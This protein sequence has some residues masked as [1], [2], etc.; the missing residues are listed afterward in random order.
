MKRT[1]V[2]LFLAYMV[3]ALPGFAQ[4]GHGSLYSYF[5]AGT[6]TY[7]NFGMA[8]RLGGVGSAVRSPYFL[9]QI[10]PASQNSLEVGF[11]FLF[12][13][14]MS[15]NYQ[16]LQTES[17]VLKNN[18]SN[19]NAFQFWFRASKKSAFS[20]G[21]TP[22]TLQDYSFSDVVTFEGMQDRYLRTYRG[23]GNTNKAYVNWAYELTDRI[24]LGIR[25]S[26]VFAN[27][28][29]ES[30]YL[31][32]TES[33]YITDRT[34]S[35]SGF[36]LE[37]GI[38][39]DLLATPKYKL[40]WG[41]NAQYYSKLTGTFNEGISTYTDRLVLYQADEE[42]S[43]F[44]LPKTIR[45]GLAFQSGKLLIAGDVLHNF[46][47]DSFEHSQ[48]SQVYALGAEF[49]PGYFAPEL[50]KSMSFSLGGRMDTG[51]WLFD[52]QS[53]KSYALTTGVGLPLNRS[54][55]VNLGYQYQKTGEI[56][57]LAAEGLHTIT[58]QFSFGDRWF[59]RYKFE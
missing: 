31:N 40:T 23:W 18:F 4:R 28:Q 55:R 17:E 50:L 59:Q 8:K 42:A 20:L 2:I 45:T 57:V 5:G 3:T 15:Y 44:E 30:T 1:S 49:V 32:A 47:T 10:N 25:P 29:K 19:L 52:G 56:Q 36:G 38:Q 48:A 22:V 51:S 54:T 35:N 37:A 58:L 53:V 27:Y 7:D 39:A 14:D 26:F 46:S 41:A 34:G 6:Y 13:G 16:Q 9:N 12:E 33:G 24:S 21:L 11:T 43:S